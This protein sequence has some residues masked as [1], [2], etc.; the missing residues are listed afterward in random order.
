MSFPTKLSLSK[1]FL[2]A[3]ALALAGFLQG[4]E[5][6]RFFGLKPNLV[7]AFLI[8]A[9]F[10][11][12]RVSRYLLLVAVGLSALRFTS[13][14]ALELALVGAIALLAFVLRVRLPGQAWVNNLTLLVLG[15]LLFYAV[16]DRAMLLGEPATVAGEV[17]YNGCVGTIAFFLLRRL[18]PREHE[19]KFRNSSRI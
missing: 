2:L 17:V 11:V 7:L 14:F 12:G 18:F 9:S 8:A 5:A 10:V 1:L 3:L 19:A 13:P 4:T 15:T 16:V 6:V